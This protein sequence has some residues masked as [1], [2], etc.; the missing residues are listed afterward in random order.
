MY[1]VVHPNRQQAFTLVEIMIAIAVMSILAAIGIQAFRASQVKHQ[2][3]GEIEECIGAIQDTANIG[4]SCR[5]LEI[6]NKFIKSREGEKLAGRV[7]ITKP[8][9]GHITWT[10]WKNGR[11]V[12]GGFIGGNYSNEVI[13][14]ADG[15]SARARQG[16]KIQQGAALEISGDG[17]SFCII[18]MPDGTPLLGGEIAFNLN[19]SSRSIRTITAKVS[20]VGRVTTVTK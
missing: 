2:F 10:I 1:R 9:D 19:S 14:E 16:S 15:F 18:Y 5:F 12:R 4:K 11:R 20:S 8:K 3:M 7:K 17:G 6:D 13:I